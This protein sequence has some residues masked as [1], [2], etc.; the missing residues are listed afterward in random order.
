MGLALHNFGKELH[1]FSVLTL[2][3]LNIAQNEWVFLKKPEYAGLNSF[4]LHL[5]ALA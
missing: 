4:P 2:S 1:S 5:P 3:K